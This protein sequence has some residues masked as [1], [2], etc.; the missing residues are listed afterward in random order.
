MLTTTDRLEYAD[1]A[2]LYRATT[3][4]RETLTHLQHY[5]NVTQGRRIPI[6]W[7]K[8]EIPTPKKSHMESTH[9]RI[10]MKNRI[11]K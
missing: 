9:Y 1:G 11:Q 10:R 6:Q 2:I 7:A 5:S 3:N 4:N 8:T